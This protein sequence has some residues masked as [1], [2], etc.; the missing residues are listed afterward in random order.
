M[1]NDEDLD[2]IQHFVVSYL[3]LVC[4]PML[5]CP[6]MLGTHVNTLTGF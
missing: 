2:Q 5:F 4:L 3:G 6:N 1:A